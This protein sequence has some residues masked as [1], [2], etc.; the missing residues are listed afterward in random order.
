MRAFWA[1]SAALPQAGARM[2]QV[3]SSGLLRSAR[4]RS[5]VVAV[6]GSAAGARLEAQH[7]ADGHPDPELTTRVQHL[8]KK[9]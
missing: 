7:A 2:R 3:G 9:G 8:P 1:E 5:E 4:R 6:F